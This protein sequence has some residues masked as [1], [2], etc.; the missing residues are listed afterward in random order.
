VVV[1]WGLDGR[2]KTGRYNAGSMMLIIAAE[3]AVLWW[4]G[5]WA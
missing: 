3:A 4:G 5:F 2:P 1:S